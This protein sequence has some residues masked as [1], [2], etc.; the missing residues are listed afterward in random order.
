MLFPPDGD[1]G[2]TWCRTFLAVAT[3]TV[4]MYMTGLDAMLAV[5]YVTIAA[6]QVRTDGAR[7]AI[8]VYVWSLLAI[9]AGELLVAADVAPSLLSEDREH[10][11]AALMAI[12]MGPAILL[13]GN[14]AGERERMEQTSSRLLDL[15]HLLADARTRRDIA[16]RLADAVPRVLELDRAVV[17]LRDGD[18]LQIA[19]VHGFTPELEADV[20]ALP[21]SISVSPLVAEIVHGPPKM[22]YLDATV[23][24]PFV[25]GIVEYF[26]SVESYAAPVVTGG[27]VTAFIIA[28]RAAGRAQGLT[29][30]LRERL[31]GLAHQAAIALENGRLIEQ[32]QGVI[33]QLR[34]ADRLKS[35]FLAVVSHELRTPLSVMLGAARTLQWRGAEL[36]DETRADLVE[37]IVRRGE[38]LNRLV[39]DL[40]QAS[41]DI[42]LELAPIDV[43]ATARTAVADARTLHP[44]IRISC[45]VPDGPVMV[46][47]DA[48]RVRQIVDNLVEN[49]YKYAEG[50]LVDV[51][52][53]WEGDDAVVTVADT[54]PGMSSEAADRA[55][56]AFYQGD[57][58]AVRR[59]GGLGLGLHICRR[60]AEA[61]GGHITLDSAPGEGTR[62]HVRLPAAGPV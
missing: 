20:R 39:E 25:R 52:V 56:D 43:A 55:F 35:E 22:V 42:Q 37:S 28:D 62:V 44:D 14:V 5:G 23:D 54:G 11:L 17:I 4:P 57:S 33:A 30:V 32:E 38:Q 21:L 13:F 40:L 12:I 51:T 15:A 41:G 58:S 34:E 29:P 10:G 47:A 50:G 1:I 18:D 31:T 8:P 16:Q 9:G 7:A 6:D 3:A 27:T 59:V 61:H 36:S 2:A 53:G 19:G 60:I 46:R 45:S 24:D 48:F 26:G 49:A